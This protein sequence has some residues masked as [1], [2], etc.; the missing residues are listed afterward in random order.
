MR[1]IA[2][3]FLTF[4][5]P[6]ITIAGSLDANASNFIPKKANQQLD[7]ISLQLSV[8]NLN[9]NNLNVAVE[10]LSELTKKAESCIDEA[11][12]KLDGLDL[13]LNQGSDKPN[14]NPTT[15]TKSADF[16]YLSNEQKK[17]ADKQA[18][19]RLFI[20][21]AKEAM[22]AYKTAI[23]ALKQEETM[24]RGIPIWKLIKQIIVLP[25]G[26]ALAD[27]SSISIPPM[28]QSFFAWGILILTTLLVA[29]IL[30]FHGLKSRF[31]HRYLRAEK[32]HFGYVT[33]VACSLMAIVLFA[34]LMLYS[35]AVATA[36][37]LL[38]PAE[39]TLI[40]LLGILIILLIFRL[41]KIKSL[42]AWYKL[43]IVFFK[44]LA[45]W[46]LSIYQV[47]R[48][49]TAFI[50]PLKVNPLMVQ[51][52]QECYL[53]FL[54]GMQIYFIYRFCQAHLSIHF[55]R[56]HQRFIRH[57]GTLILILFAS[58]EIMGYHILATRLTYS[59]LI[60]IAILFFMVLAI[61]GLNKLY[62]L[63]KTH[64]PTRK[65]IMKQFGYQHDDAFTE[66]LVLKTTTQ[67]SIVI[68]GIL[69]MVGHWEF[70]TNY[71]LD[72]SGQLLNGIHIANFTLYPTR[73]LSGII[74]FCLLYLLF[75]AIATTISRHQQFE[76]DEEETQVAIA[77]ILT[78]IGFGLA[79]I[80]GLLVAGF[81]FTALAIVA[82][83][84]SVGI[85]LGLQSIVN[86]FVSGI[87][88]LIEKPIKP[89]D[90]I[91]IDGT[92]GCV[93]KISVRSTLVLTPAREDIIIP[94]SDLITKKVINYT[95]HD[96]YLSIRCEVKISQNNDI[97]LVQKLLLQ[98]ANE[99]E[100]VVKN[101]RNKPSVLLSSFDDKTLVFQLWCLIKDAHNKSTIQS[102][103]NYAIHRLFK[104]QQI[105]FS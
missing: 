99:H 17:W 89:G 43:N 34:Y 82:G 50:A 66:F 101:S 58:L 18:Q 30:I 90:R 24:E 76:D 91:N 59:G 53:L 83:A 60:S 105:Q 7:Q 95:Y 1:T 6:P 100:D 77:S 93:K 73:I 94:N 38:A 9:L 86:N 103:L 61:H 70:T 14:T 10:T 67:I 41:K 49:I 54:I 32:I 42:F 37:P 55:I 5:I 46:L 102:E 15:N 45:L 26:T 81:D 52:G 28:F 2:F 25:S 21:R 12:D 56:A 69:F 51:L 27:F 75:R 85:G 57:T 4:L 78:Y 79:V 97:E 40:Y 3:F 48:I 62:L 8:Q 20:I 11:K 16:V 80:A 104:Q 64:Q 96:R 65:I 22:S 23:T 71:M 33:L 13:M 68:V 47:K 19:C 87:I 35:D 31:A 39:P 92:E 98:V 63:L 36:N 88:L 74:V 72:L 29:T 84:L 44:H